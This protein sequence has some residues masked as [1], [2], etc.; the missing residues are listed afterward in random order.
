M[1]ASEHS[2]GGFTVGQLDGVF[3]DGVIDG[4]DGTVSVG[5]GH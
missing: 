1:L 5:T 3:S 2:S 4:I